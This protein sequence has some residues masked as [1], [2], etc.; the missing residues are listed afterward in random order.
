MRGAGASPAE[1]GARLE[2][3]RTLPP[4]PA[5]SGPLKLLGDV[6]EHCAQRACDPEVAE[7]AGLAAVDAPPLR[8]GEVT[9]FLQVEVPLAL[10]SLVELAPLPLAEAGRTLGHMDDADRSA[11]VGRWLRDPLTVEER[12][13]FWLRVA[14]APVLEL[15][16]ASVA[17]SAKGARR[18]PL[19]AAPPQVAVVAEESGEF[20]AGS[21]RSLVCSR[22]AY[23]WNF[24]RAIC[25][26]CGEE[27]STLI[28]SYTPEDQKLAR[29]DACDTCSGYIKTF[30]LRAPGALEVVPLVDDVAT[31]ALDVWAH[32]QGFQ[33]AS[34]SLAGV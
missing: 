4:T 24:G 15:A 1:F 25:P 28:H 22:C 20:L 18:C 9:S 30:D 17:T 29:I 33:R 13:G 32:D 23:S 7:V 14:A 27:N 6:L 21:P 12:S 26:W 8:L 19:C 5:N 3:V 16:A 10:D 11:V 2:R 31:L 34:V